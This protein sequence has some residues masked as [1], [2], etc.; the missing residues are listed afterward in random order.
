M[1]IKGNWR[2]HGSEVVIGWCQRFFSRRFA[3]LFR[4]FAG[5]CS[6]APNEKKTSG[7]QGMK[8]HEMFL[9]L[10]YVGESKNAAITCCLGFAFEKNVRQG[11]VMIIVRFSFVCV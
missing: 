5:Q 8:T 2:R 6:V 11:K 9:H 10:H 3:T 1:S 7:T 4:R